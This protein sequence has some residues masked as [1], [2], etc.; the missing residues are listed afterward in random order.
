MTRT[1]LVG[2]PEYYGILAEIEK[3]FTKPR[4]PS[5]RTIWKKGFKAPWVTLRNRKNNPNK[6]AT[7]Q[8]RRK[9]SIAFS[10]VN[11]PQYGKRG[12]LSP[13]WKGGLFS[14]QERIRPITEYK[15][16]RK[17][18]FARDCFRC[19]ICGKDSNHDLEAHHIKSLSQI[20]LD[21][22]TRTV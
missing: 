8:V 12:P 2:A 16:W 13:A 17:A 18:V 3:S 5:S 11:N 14:L 6:S 9:L 21:N 22:N 10:G 19:R 15:I 20:F 4:R 7:E 1:L